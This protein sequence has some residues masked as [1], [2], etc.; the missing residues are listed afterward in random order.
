MLDMLKEKGSTGKL[1]ILEQPKEE[2][3]VDLT[4]VVAEVEGQIEQA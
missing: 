1:Q 4:Q 2:A 3:V